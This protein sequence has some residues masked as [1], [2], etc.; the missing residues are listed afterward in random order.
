MAEVAESIESTILADYR[1]GGSVAVLTLN[2]PHVLN[3]MSTEMGLRLS[4]VLEEVSEQARVRVVILTGAGERAFCAGGDLKQRTGMTPEQWV[5]QHRIFEAAHHRLRW[6]RKPVFAAVNGIAA[7]GGCEMAMSTD[8]IVCSDNA[9]FGQ[10]EV[11]RGIMPGAGGTQLL[12]RCLPRGRAFELLMTGEL[13]G[14]HDA[15]RWGLVNHVVPL[16]ELMPTA[17]ELALRIAANSPAAVQQAKRAARMGLEQ[18]IEQ[19][20]EIEL[21]CYR[22]MVDHPDRFEGVAAFNER[23]KPEFEDCY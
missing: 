19:A 7:G 9:R 6:L 21:E 10:P 16:K 15:H 22:R 8:F 11:S 2:R 20:I 4:Q 18:P 14:A 3:A 12:P 1:H 5:R 13:I 17:E 23:R